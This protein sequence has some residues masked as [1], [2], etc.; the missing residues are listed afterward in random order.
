MLYLTFSVG[1]KSNYLWLNLVLLSSFTLELVKRKWCHKT[2]NLTVVRDICIVKIPPF[3][4]FRTST[5]KLDCW[6]KWTGP[7]AFCLIYQQFSFAR[8]GNC[9]QETIQSV[10][11]NFQNENTVC[12][13][14]KMQ[15]YCGGRLFAQTR[16]QQCCRLLVATLPS[17]TWK[18]FAFY[19]IVWWFFK[20]WWVRG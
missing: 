10:L 13:Y 19:K 1:L 17:V 3:C 5:E 4:D 6:R 15:W 9:T 2:G 18:S 7:S 8:Y 11:L 12:L 14:N 16:L 20:V